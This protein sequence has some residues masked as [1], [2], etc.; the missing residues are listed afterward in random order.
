M[1]LNGLRR[2]AILGSTGS[3][4]VQALD[5]IERLPERF[6]VVALAAGRN[7][8]LLGRQVLKHRPRLVAIDD[9]SRRRALEPMARE[10]G[11]EL[12]A[13]GD[14]VMAVASHAEADIV[15]AAIVGAAGLRATYHAVSC[16]KTVALAN[17]ESLVM[18]G[19]LMR[20]TSAE[21]GGTLIPVD[22]EHSALHQCLRGEKVEEVRRLILTASGGP[23]L[24]T[25]I[26]KLAG[27]TPREALRHPVWDMGKKISIDSA[28]LMNKGLEV[29]EA[30][31][32]FSLPDDRIDVVLH[33]QSRVHSMVEMVDGSMMCQ[34]GVPDMRGP[35]QYALGYPDRFAGPV[36]PLDLSRPQTLEFFPVDRARFPSLDLAY[37][38]LRAGGTTPVA[39][40]AAN[41]VGVQAFLDS[42]IGFL[43]IAR[44]VA[45]VLERHRPGRA[46]SI[47]EVLESDGHARRIAAE[48]LSMEVLS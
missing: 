17:K 38:A 45:A 44:L 41:E 37:A 20:R 26:E 3:V 33:P 13:G 35:I 12:V 18:A 10:V 31:W 9:E 23:F 43:G 16:G 24:H 5:L 42:R 11:A 8:D 34:I 29:I 36:P 14:G 25:P 39:L 30:H 48:V 6:E 40:N 19:E 22:S 1:G 28:T 32:L 4:G 46:A 7:A 27:V 2:V 15:L 21:A 47:E